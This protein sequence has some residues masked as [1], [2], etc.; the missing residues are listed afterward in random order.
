M[1]WHHRIADDS[2]NSKNSVYFPQKSV[3]HVQMQKR[4]KKTLAELSIA[5]ANF[6]ETTFFAG[7]W[8]K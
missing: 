3:L 7:F 8:A 1:A 6:S 5:T 2:K 4:K